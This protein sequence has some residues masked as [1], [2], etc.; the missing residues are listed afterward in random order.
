MPGQRGT[1]KR[2][3]ADQAL[4][5]LSPDLSAL[6]SAAADA[7]GLT[8][9]AWLRG[10]AVAAVGADSSE[11][12]PSKPRPGIPSDDVISI[13]LLREVVAELSGAM[14][15]AAIKTRID[16]AESLHAEI[17]AAIPGIKAAVLDLDR[18]KAKLMSAP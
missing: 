16:G 14:V 6:V 13:A 10:L 15:K 5:R 1:E 3:M 17:E 8:V 4:V 11:V 2:A 7:A 18:L 12:R 9:P